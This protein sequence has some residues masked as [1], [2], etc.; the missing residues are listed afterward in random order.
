MNP[1]GYKE[2]FMF[3]SDDSPER[4]KEGDI[5]ITISPYKIIKI[6]KRVINL[7]RTLKSATHAVPLNVYFF[8]KLMY[9]Q[10]CRLLRDKTNKIRV[11][12][13]LYRASFAINNEGTFIKTRYGVEKGENICTIYNDLLKEKVSQWKD[14]TLK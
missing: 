13:L 12:E 2:Y 7:V 9:E 5:N 6:S 11:T 14:L 8:D 1:K 10:M 4:L 3:G